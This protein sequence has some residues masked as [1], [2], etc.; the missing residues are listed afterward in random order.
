M[1]I[2]KMDHVGIVVKDLQAVKHFFTTLGLE[3]I[4]EQD[5]NG[6]WIKQIYGAEADEATIAMMKVPHG[7][8]V[9]EL[10]NFRG[11]IDSPEIFTHFPK[12][13]G[14]SHFAFS[15]QNIEQVV[16][17]L[18]STTA[19]IIGD[20]IQYEDIYKLCYIKGPEGIFVELAE[21]L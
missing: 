20:I 2:E 10:I 14:A 17:N 15:I 16:A 8:T 19:H 3:L 21:K 12:Y 9:I 5:V 13:V 1:K 7:E 11:E 6:Q 4:G 18:K